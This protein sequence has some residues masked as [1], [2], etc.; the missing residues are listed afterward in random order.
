[1]NICKYKYNITSE[2][3]RFNSP[4]QFLLDTNIISAFTETVRKRC[5]WDHKTSLLQCIYRSIS[6]YDIS[7][8]QTEIL[9]LVTEF[10]LVGLWVY[11]LSSPRLLNLLVKTF[12]C[13]YIDLRFLTFA[14]I[15]LF[16]F[17]LYC[18][19]PKYLD[20]FFVSLIHT[21]VTRLVLV[22]ML[23][24]LNTNSSKLTVTLCY[25]L[26]TKPELSWFDLIFKEKFFLFVFFCCLR[27]ILI[28]SSLLPVQ[29]CNS[30]HRW[31]KWR[32]LSLPELLPASTLTRFF[33]PRL[34]LYRNTVL[35]SVFLLLWCPPAAVSCQLHSS[36]SSLILIIT[37]AYTPT[38][39]R[40][41][42]ADPPADG[43]RCSACWSSC[44]QSG[45]SAAFSN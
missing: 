34:Y 6:I 4:L 16:S 27:L 42:G 41:E 7:V 28:V 18:F 2:F 38:Q 3:Q 14:E 12:K 17:V 21:K 40:P 25:W 33:K 39:G 15:F 29:K 8:L 1:M 43:G 26:W 37:A 20:E 10:R 45:G 32:L 13:L 24:C 35:H 23:T 5:R 31:R 11:S 44:S 22:S 19:A 9:Q 30:H 36:S